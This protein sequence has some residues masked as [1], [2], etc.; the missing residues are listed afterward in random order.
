MKPGKWKQRDGRTAKIIERSRP[1]SKCP[2]YGINGTG[3][4]SVWADDGIWFPSGAQS[5]YDLTE[6]L[7]PLEGDT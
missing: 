7:G 3:W 1:K 4:P 5:Q 2:W 6:Y